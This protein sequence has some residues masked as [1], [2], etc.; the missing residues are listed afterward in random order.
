[1]AT[2]IGKLLVAIVMEDLVYMTEKFGLLP[3]NHFGGCPGRSTT[4]SMH[5][6]I[7]RI[8][9]GWQ[10]KKVAV[11]VFLDI[12]GSFPNAVTDWLLHNMR[13]QRVPEEY[14]QFTQ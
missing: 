7:H 8:K 5:L 1:M 9:G 10:C 12:E 13:K 11:M 6:V 4:D 2:C 14:V 3:A